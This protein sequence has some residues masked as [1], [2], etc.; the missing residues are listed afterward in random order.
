MRPSQVFIAATVFLALYVGGTT[1][2]TSLYT[3]HNV[4]D[5]TSLQITQEY[6]ELQKDIGVG[7]YQ[8]ESGS[9]YSIIKGR[10][11]NSGNLVQDVVAGLLVVPKFID[12]LLTPIDI[13]DST[14]NGL[15]QEFSYLPSWI[16]LTLKILIYSTLL[17]GVFGLIIGMRA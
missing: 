3:N 16:F 13:V 10:E 8:N 9:L 17:Y 6:D 2:L 4:Q 14:L 5:Q 11:F 1:F 7:Q 15:Q 12:I